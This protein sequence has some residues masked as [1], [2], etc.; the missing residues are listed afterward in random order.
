MRRYRSLLLALLLLFGELGW[1]FWTP[2][3]GWVRHA[4]ESLQGI[5][6]TNTPKLVPNPEEYAVLTREVERWRT[7]LATR[8][9]N[10]PSPEERAQ[11]VSD[12]RMLLE[13]AM[14]AMMRCWLGTPYDFNGTASAPGSDKIACGYFVATVLK[15]AGFR[16]NRYRLAQQPSE[17]ILRTF[18]SK[19]SCLLKIGVSYDHFTDD[20]S[21]LEPG[22][23]VLGLDTHVGFLLIDPSGFRFIHSSGRRPWCVVEQSRDEALV[24]KLSNWRML[25]N[26]TADPDL[27][28][29]W[30][31]GNP[32]AVHGT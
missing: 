17:N 29:Q 15:D 4:E 28:R 8:Y 16:V 19:D 3:S 20:I 6:L 11:V 1:L 25:G 12:A 14:P 9:A 13:K 7:D 32:I 21:S 24:V 22:I 10:A 5:R 26:L 27:I 2:I 23:Y 18:L 31:E 30:L